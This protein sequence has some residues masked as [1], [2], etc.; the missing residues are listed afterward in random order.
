VEDNEEDDDEDNLPEV[1]LPNVKVRLHTC[2]NMYLLD[3]E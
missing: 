1:P 3:L 2:I